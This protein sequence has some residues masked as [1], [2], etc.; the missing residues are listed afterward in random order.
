MVTHFADYDN[1]VNRMEAELDKAAGIRY[2]QTTV[3]PTDD[4]WLNISAELTLRSLVHVVGT[5][6]VPP[7]VSLVQV[8]V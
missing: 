7:Q 5:K 2:P 3:Q 6:D 8:P 1:E 4:Q